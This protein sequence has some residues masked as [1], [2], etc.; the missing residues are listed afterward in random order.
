MQIHRWTKDFVVNRSPLHGNQ[1]ARCSTHFGFKHPGLNEAGRLG[2]VRL[3]VWSGFLAIALLSANA[4]RSEAQQP[5]RPST[6]PVPAAVKEDD[7][8][9]GFDFES[10]SKS[11]TDADSETLREPS[12]GNADPTSTNPVLQGD[13]KPTPR[14][15]DLAPS[16]DQ[17]PPPPTAGEL[18]ELSQ[19]IRWLAL[20]NLPE[21]IEDNR[22]WG[23]QKE[24][25]NG[26]HMRMD[27]L[28][29]DTKRKW[30]TVNHGTWSRYFIEFIDPAQRLQID[31]R[32]LQVHPTGRSFSTSVAIVAPLKLFARVSQFNRD[33][34]L[35]SLSTRADAVV[36]MQIDCDVEIRINP[37]V[38]PPEVEF[39]P[40]ITHAAVQLQ[41]FE[42][43]EVSQVRGEAAEWLGQAIRKILQRKLDDTNDKLIEKMNAS[44]AKQQHRL[45]LSAQAWFDSSLSQS[46]TSSD[47]PTVK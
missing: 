44:I 1:P 24:V 47:P 32:K 10:L 2:A 25:Y 31:V 5:P 3:R 41:Q 29:L 7:G 12:A 38:L 16:L 43:H 21:N 4:N 15:L 33:V 45:K 23:R 22:K 35:F 11:N 14:R 37:L 8:L 6:I 28:R 17:L 18:Q 13:E 19:W 26:V 39:R 27:G 36:A 30:K 20:M 34:Q 9:F 46:R 40:K 42:V